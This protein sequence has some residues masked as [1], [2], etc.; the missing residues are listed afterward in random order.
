MKPR[1]LDLF[2]GAGGAAM[3]YHRAGFEVVGVDVRPQPH[4][5]FRFIQHDALSVL[6]TYIADP[7]MDGPFDAIHASPP[8]QAFT[9]AKHLRVAQGGS[10]TALDLVDPTRALLR[11]LGLPYVIENVP[12]APLHGV[13]LC[14]SSFGLKVRRHRVFESNV[15]IPPL[16]CHHKAQGRP[17][18]VY[19]VLNDHV[20]QGGTTA[21][22]L[23]EANAAM[24]IDWM[25]W[26]ELKEAI[27]PAY[28]TWIGEHLLQVVVRAA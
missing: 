10:T 18:G 11:R 2:C 20:P 6:R 13:T 22:T 1:M 27:P 14:G 9:R 17:V 16:P 23:D 19:H 5:P 7:L 3:G 12:G 26:N 28:T 25:T 21:K 24:G 4:Y 15:Y 8:C